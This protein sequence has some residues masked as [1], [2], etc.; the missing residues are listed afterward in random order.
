MS[1]FH[2]APDI[3]TAVTAANGDGSPELLFTGVM[4]YFPNEDAVLWFVAEVWP[5]VRKR[6]SNARFTIAGMNP[7]QKIRALGEH[8]GIE[9]TGFVDDMLPY[10]QRA[11]IFVASFQLARGIQNKVLQALACGLPVVTSKPGVE[12]IDCTPGT[13]LLV[14]EQP[15]E[16]AA[17]I[18]KLVCDAGLY[19]QVS[20]AGLEL[21]AEQFSWDSKNARLEEILMGDTTKP[22]NVSTVHK[23]LSD[24]A[25]VRGSMPGAT[26]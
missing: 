7:S 14:A 2:P 24:D 4:D 8:P 22:A 3:D 1:L 19:R 5:A 15:Q 6:F 9:I 26:P 17:A 13:H 21:V 12:G 20:Q 18:E 10:Y 23:P 16:F 11:D 25:S